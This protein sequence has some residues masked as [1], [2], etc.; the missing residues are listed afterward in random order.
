MIAT[1]RD[2]QL[3]AEENRFI[4]RHYPKIRRRLRGGLRRKGITAN[5]DALNEAAAWFCRNF[6]DDSLRQNVPILSARVA[7]AVWYAVQRVADRRPATGCLRD[8]PKAPYVDAIAPE[9]AQARRAIALQE[10]GL[11]RSAQDWRLC[12]IGRCA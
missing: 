7:A 3:T 5:P 2:G 12:D 6:A 11:L 10:G 9:H 4:A 8:N 1:A